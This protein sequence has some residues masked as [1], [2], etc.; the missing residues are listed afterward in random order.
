LAKYQSL[1]LEFPSTPAFNSLWVL[2]GFLFAGCIVAVRRRAA[3]GYTIALCRTMGFVLM[4]LVIGNLNVLPVSLLL[5]AVPW[6]LAEVAL[7]I[8]FAQKSMGIAE[9]A[10]VPGGEA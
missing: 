10:H 3:S 8:V 6:S 9:A 5:I 2:S 4:W 1:G 7:A